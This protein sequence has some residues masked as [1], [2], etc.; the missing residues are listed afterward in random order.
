MHEDLHE[1]NMSFAQVLEMMFQLGRIL[2]TS[3]GGVR[4]RGL[5]TGHSQYVARSNKV[6]T[7]KTGP[8]ICYIPCLI[9]SSLNAAFPIPERDSIRKLVIGLCAPEVGTCLIAGVQML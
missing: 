1:L 9:T 8:R 4:D 2:M 7:T 3:I 6:P 5:C